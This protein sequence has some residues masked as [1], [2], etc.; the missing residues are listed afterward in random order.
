LPGD[1]LTKV[2]RMSMANSLE[3][4]VPFLD[5][6]FAEYAFRLR[7]NT[8][9]KG[10]GGKYILMEAFKDLLPTSIH[11]RPKRG[12]EMPI[13]GGFEM[14]IGA[15]LKNELKFL[16]DEYLS[17]N[18]IKKQGFFDFEIIKGLI[19]NHISGRRDTS[20]QLWSL[21]VFQHWYKAYL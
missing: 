9:L 19:N 3:V 6:T 1:M 10:K 14:P 12:F 16:I 11:R 21:I 20:W 5:H 2:D 13:G 15:W 8:K 18:S 7:G 4:R 17:E